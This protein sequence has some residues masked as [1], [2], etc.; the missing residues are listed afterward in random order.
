MRRVA[1]NALWLFLAEIA[2]KAAG[3]ALVV[4]VA[5][6]LGATSYGYFN[7]ALSF[8]PLFLIFA[9]WGMG[10]TLVRE[11]ADHRGRAPELLASALAI[12]TVLGAAGLGLAFLFGP[13][14]VPA[15]TAYFVLVL[16]GLA[17]FADALA[18]IVGA[19]FQAFEQMQYQAITI[20][21][22]RIVSTLLALVAIVLGA[23]LVTVASTYLAGSA[24]ALALAVIFVRRRFGGLHPNLVSRDAVG[25]LLGRGLPLGLAAFLNMAVFRLDAVM[26]QA[27]RGASAVGFYG[28]GYRFFE[29]FLFPS[30]IL[31]Q[32][33]LP[34]MTRLGATRETRRIFELACAVV[35][36]LLLPVVV[37]LGFASHWVVVTLFSDD[38]APASSVVAV[39]AGATVLYGIA[40]LARMTLVALGH[41]RIIAQVAGAAVVVNVAL[42]AWAIPRWSFRGAAWSTLATELLEALLLV[43]ALSRPLGMPRL[44]RAGLLPALLAGGLAL[45]LWALDLHGG[46]A[47]LVVAVAYPP[48][49]VLAAAV[50]APEELRRARG[51]LRRRPP[52][53]PEAAAGAAP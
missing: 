43:T 13:L 9:N 12:L 37:A 20:A 42:N 15:G 1:T 25:L 49:L 39:L 46:F 51:L 53:A 41:R 30:W 4:I 17:L 36:A 50:F 44:G 14:F 52:S 47:L 28:V 11:I 33:A 38:F 45:L 24:V 23:G 6:G 10:S 16:V 29:S 27:L 3:F 7:F 22:N 21:T 40:H 48:L 5:R 18:A 19:V 2:N 34:R 26:L 35:L 32:A 8:V 31:G